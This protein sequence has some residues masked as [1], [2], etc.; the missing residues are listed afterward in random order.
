MNFA[1]NEDFETL[2][3]APRV[4]GSWLVNYFSKLYPVMLV[5]GSTVA[6]AVCCLVADDFANTFVFKDEGHHKF[7][8]GLLPALNDKRKPVPNTEL[9]KMSRG[10][11]AVMI[12]AF[13]IGIFA[14]FFESN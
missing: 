8:F 14:C 1:R 9:I 2:I 12:L 6:I 4:Q 7:L 13:V 11:V 10:F 3:S 5:L